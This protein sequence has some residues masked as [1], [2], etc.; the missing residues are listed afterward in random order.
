VLTSDLGTV[1]TLIDGI[2]TLFKNLT[3]ARGD[4]FATGRAINGS[5]LSLLLLSFTC[6]NVGSTL[7][8]DYL[9][10]LFSKRHVRCMSNKVSLFHSLNFDEITMLI[11]YPRYDLSTL[12]KKCNTYDSTNLI[13]NTCTKTALYSVWCLL[14][15]N[16]V[17]FIL[18][19]G[20]LSH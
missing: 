1:H 9:Q 17:C 15:V 10:L 16:S 12:T 4:M 14:F 13:T 19:R 11:I 7:S 18:K 20:Y 8:S 6:R 2:I 5:C 3:R